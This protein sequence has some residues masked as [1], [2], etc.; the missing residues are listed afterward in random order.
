MKTLLRSLVI[1][2][3]LILVTAVG[4]SV[5]NQLPKFKEIQQAER[6]AQKLSQEQTDLQSR[7]KEENSPSFV[8]GEARDKLGYQQPGEALYVVDIGEG[9]GGQREKKPKENWQEW[10]D[11]FFR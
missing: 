9:K 8:E 11:L 7:Q 6:K 5:Y 3:L 1:L 4:R 2:V 10:F